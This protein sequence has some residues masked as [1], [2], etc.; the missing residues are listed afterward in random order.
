MP[1]PDPLRV[2]TVAVIGAG[3]IGASW[4]ALCLAQGIAVRVYDPAPDGETSVRRYVENAWPALKR[5]FPSA[6][7]DPTRISFHP[8]PEGAAAGADFVQES[9]TERVDLKQELL[10]RIDAVVAPDRVIASSTSTYVVTTMNARMRHPERLVVGHPFNP[11]HL[12]PLVEVVGGEGVDSGA[13]DWALAFY[14]GLGKH[15]IRLNKAVLAH[16]ANRLQAAL[17]REA[18]NLVN[19]GV[20]S[21]GDID[22]AIAYGPGLRWAVMGPSLVFH[23]AAGSGGM[24]QFLKH[25]SGPIQSH[26]D[27]LGAPRLT[28]EV[29]RRL[30]EGVAEEARGRSVAELAAERDRCLV[31]ILEVLA[32][33]RQG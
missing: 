22:A 28:P 4:A 2:G 6:R 27:D 5:L 16:V 3:T 17:W 10:A 21:V 7:G 33:E 15:P 32:R 31:G 11:P 24:E 8:E 19:E 9:A 12:I 29:N 25:L 1:Y 20:A 18:V 23:L 13:I 14:K 26:W 30:I